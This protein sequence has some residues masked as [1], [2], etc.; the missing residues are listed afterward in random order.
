[1]KGLQTLGFN[2]NWLFGVFL[3][4]PQSIVRRMCIKISV[5]RITKSKYGICITHVG[6]E[7]D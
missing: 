4:L 5:P 2:E 6:F 1:M 3:V 7:L